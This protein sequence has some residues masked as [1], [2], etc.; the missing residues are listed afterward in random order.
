MILNGEVVKYS[1]IL[2]MSIPMDDKNK[3]EYYKVSLMQIYLYFSQFKFYKT[4]YFSIVFFLRPQMALT[5]HDDEILSL[6]E[7]ENESSELFSNSDGFSL[8]DFLPRW[9]ILQGKELRLAVKMRCACP[10]ET[11]KMAIRILQS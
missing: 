8:H 6:E 2:D 10:F 9:K 11:N 7:F 4:I 3:D 5:F 1:P